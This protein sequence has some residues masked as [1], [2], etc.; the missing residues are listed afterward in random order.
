[1][2]GTNAA[3]LG[4]IAG[5]NT[6][7]RSS[8]TIV[9]GTTSWKAVSASISHTA[10]IDSTDK[11]WTWGLNNAGQM[12]DG[13]TAPKS[14]PVLIGSS[15]WAQISAG[16]SFTGAID[17][18]G[19]LHTWGLGTTGEIGINLATSRSSPTQVGS[20]LAAG[21][22]LHP[23][24]LTLTSWSQVSAGISF[25]AAISSN[26]LLWEWGLNNVGQI[27]DG[28]SITKSSPVQIGSS[29]WS[30]VSAG[31]NHVMGLTSVKTLFVWGG[32]A[33]G[34]LG[35]GNT[36]PNLSVP[37]TI[38]SLSTSSFSAVGAGISYSLAATIDGKL[39]TW[40][41]GTSGQLGDN[42]TVTRTSPG[43]LPIETI[44]ASMTPTDKSAYAAI[45]WPWTR[46]GRAHITGINPFSA[47]YNDTSIYGGSI[48]LPDGSSFLTAAVPSA[49]NAF[50]IN[51][52][53]D[54]TIE[55][56]IYRTANHGSSYDA[57]VFGIDTVQWWTLC[58]QA[59][60][61]LS[62]DRA[63][64]GVRFVGSVLTLGQWY[65][66]ALT[67]IGALNYVYRKWHIRYFSR[68]FRCKSMV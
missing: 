24:E 47:P 45:A 27:G 33:G 28:T 13:T 8:P 10:A 12:G 11:L 44:E 41:L 25:V 19:R 4:V 66:I 21:S 35:Q 2:W 3:G 57:P 15:S 18:T 54:F 32:N 9:S 31:G 5:G 65:H 6:V 68:W 26:N 37:T 61:R 42:S 48:Y 43:Y 14:S 23:I 62:V 53:A 55:T 38:A 16:T 60:G 67:R 7:A 1:M 17:S 63:S 36:T 64:V 39:W 56:W 34:Q 50:H 59:S 58:I 49:V 52:L 30:Q 22:I 40:G 51:L 20:Y 46:N 29:S